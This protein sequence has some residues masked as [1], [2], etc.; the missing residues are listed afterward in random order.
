MRFLLS[1]QSSSYLSLDC[2]SLCLVCLFTKFS[3]LFYGFCLLRGFSFLG[4]LLQCFLVLCF[5]GC[6][7]FCVFL[8]LLLSILLSLFSCFLHGLKFCLKSCF[9][10][11]MFSLQGFFHCFL[12]SLG[13]FQFSFEA[14]TF[15]LLCS[16]CCLCFCFSLCLGLSD[17]FL[18]C[19]ASPVLNGVL[20]ELGADILSI[21]TVTLFLDTW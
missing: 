4:C 16:F 12:S 2:S 9:L 3:L 15:G 17:S 20:D 18:G 6:F 13:L 21:I 11:R 5:L 7:L 10:C 1:G 8:S 14:S 19:Y